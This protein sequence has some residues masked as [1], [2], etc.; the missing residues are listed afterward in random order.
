MVLKIKE[1]I[2][3]AY[4]NGMEVTK[5]D[6]SRKIWPESTQSTQQ[7]NMSRLMRGDTKN[8]KVEWI[9]LICEMLRCTPNFLF[10]YDDAKTGGNYEA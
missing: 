3:L 1:A 4:G 7:V 8:V 6:I 5:E 10:G 9:V 2:A